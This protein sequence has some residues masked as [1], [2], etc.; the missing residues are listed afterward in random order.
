VRA[1]WFEVLSTDAGDVADFYEAGGDSLRAI[2]M[3]YEIEQR[4]GVEVD[5]VAFL[6]DGTLDGLARS[7]EALRLAR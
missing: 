7:V 5:L 6:E 1:I 2:T 4:L 3:I